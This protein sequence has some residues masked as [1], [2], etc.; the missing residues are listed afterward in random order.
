LLED[1]E[2]G[3]SPIKAAEAAIAAAGEQRAEARQAEATLQEHAVEA[4]RAV[5]W[6]CRR[7]HADSGWSICSPFAVAPR[8]GW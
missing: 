2:A 7:V 4:E 3:A 8:A 1:R 5:E 6:A